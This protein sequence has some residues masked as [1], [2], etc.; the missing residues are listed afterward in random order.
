MRTT[1]HRIKRILRKRS[2]RSIMSNDSC[3]VLCRCVAQLESQLYRNECAPNG[4]GKHHKHASVQPK[5]R[6]HLL[7][8]Q[9]PTSDQRSENC[10][11][12]N[13]CDVDYFEWH[14]CDL[15]TNISREKCGLNSRQRRIDQTRH[16][17][18]LHRNE[19]PS[20]IRANDYKDSSP[21]GSDCDKK[22]ESYQLSTLLNHFSHRSRHIR[23]LTL[24]RVHLRLH[25]LALLHHR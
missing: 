8:L 24:H 7:R 3:P 17:Y 1:M 20:R 4:S 18:L 23:Y 14:S 10:G 19:C 2:R 11:Q 6:S 22:C 15:P 25:L 16:S 13:T 12:E 9:G 21:C 5:H